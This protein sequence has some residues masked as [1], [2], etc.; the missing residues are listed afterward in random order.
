MNLSPRISRAL[1]WTVVVLTFVA[2]FGEGYLAYYSSNAGEGATSWSTT[3]F[4][5]T[6]MG[7][8]ALL[9]FPV[10]GLLVA[11]R[12][13]E[14][15]IGWIM[16][17]VGVSWAIANGTTYSDYGLNYHP[18][19]L[20]LA[21]DIAAISSSFWIA[22][23]S[24]S[25]TFLL[26]LF[27]NGHL[28][29]PRWRWVARLAGFGIVVGTLS[30][31]LTP[32]K[33]GD[34]GYPHTTNPFGYSGLGGA[35]DLLQI[36]IILVPVTLLLAAVSMVLRY[37]RSR[38]VERQ[39]MKWL[40]TAAAI[41]A[42]VYAV[43]ETL[44]LSLTR[45]SANPGWLSTLQALA[46]ASFGLVPVAIGF[47]VLRY[48]LYE[49]DVII[50]RTL[51]YTVLIAMLAALYLGGIAI[52]G[53]ATRAVTGQSSAIA[54]TVSTLLVALA[55]QPLRTRINRRVERRFY[56]STYDS[57]QAVRTFST[58]L[59]EEIDLDALSHQLV[60]TVENTIQPRFV[61]IWLRSVT[62]SERSP[63][64]TEA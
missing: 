37:R 36:T 24:L 51:I 56:R 52:L 9:S 38:G 41:I 40:A 28:L 47:G 43:V 25:G 18:G 22:A 35:L 33:L 23:I 15:P 3:S 30:L 50:R 61:S 58:R 13:P 63:G 19:S 11:T 29:T 31:I 49:I 44:S 39:Q 55:F 64:K 54:V 5:S 42:L 12:R 4:L 20:P 48:R 6:A 57:E 27:P 16:I 34:A 53:A 26:L 17:A 45:H 1:A 21:N 10:V 32:G 14:N 62:I 2:F 60:A 8:A 7:A 59:R 46:I